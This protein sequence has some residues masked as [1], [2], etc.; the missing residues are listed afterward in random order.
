MTIPDDSFREAFK[1]LHIPA[2]Y[3]LHDPEQ[4]RVLFALAQLGKGSAIEVANKMAALESKSAD[5]NFKV[6]ANKILTALYRQG[7]LKGNDSS[8]TMQYNLSKITNANDG[9]VNP[10]L[11]APGLD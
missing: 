9:S 3:N 1:P 5:E 8:G 11:L 7:L 2:H 6:I 10:D 4:E